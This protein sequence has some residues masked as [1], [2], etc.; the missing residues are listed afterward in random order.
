MPRIQPAEKPPRYS[1]ARSQHPQ[2]S[3]ETQ[4]DHTKAKD[5]DTRNRDPSQVKPGTQTPQSKAAQHH[6]ENPDGP[7]QVF[8][9]RPD[10]ARWRRAEL[11]LIQVNRP[12]ICRAPRQFPQA[13][14]HGP[15][16]PQR[17]IRDN[18]THFPKPKLGQNR[19][20]CQ[21]RLSNPHQ[22]DEPAKLLQNFH[23]FVLPQPKLPFQMQ[24]KPI[25]PNCSRPRFRTC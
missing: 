3:A 16:V 13:K 5:P 1:V 20:R 12:A 4:P 6:P 23:A 21:R 24:P 25:T 15:R 17:I 2:R 18:R 10:P 8:R 19:R 14:G 7:D 9:Q 22:I 11:R